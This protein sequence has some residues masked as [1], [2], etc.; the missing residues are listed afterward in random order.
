MKNFLMPETFARKRFLR[1]Q[2]F[3]FS[4]RVHGPALVAAVGGLTRGP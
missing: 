2:R 4:A 3:A 1:R